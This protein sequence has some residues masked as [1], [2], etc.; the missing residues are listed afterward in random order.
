MPPSFIYLLV[1]LGVTCVTAMA[2]PLFL[3]PLLDQSDAAQHL[4]RATGSRLHASYV[5]NKWW[6]P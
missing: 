6:P 4:I 2:L 3:K 5:S 1:F